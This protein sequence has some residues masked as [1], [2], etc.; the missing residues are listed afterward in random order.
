MAEHREFLSRRL[1]S[2]LGVIPIGIFLVQH[3][4]VNHFA[5]YGEES[6]NKAAGFMANLPFVLV[7]ETFVIYLP[8]LFHAILGV[9]IVFEARNNTKRY[10]FFRNWMFFLQRVT[11]IITLVFIAWHVWETRVQVALGNAEV[12]YSLMEGILSSPIMFWFYIIGVVSAV[13]HFA[14]GLW[15]FA[16][17][18]GL[19]Q[20]PKSQKIATYVTVIIFFVVSYIGV[21]TLIQFAYGA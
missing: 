8:I 13:F 1:H 5:V 21:R 17:T 6:F 3:L 16:V 15:S 7:L 4:V 2:L 19:T 9:Y 10:G 14:N 20:S 11:G 18:W 12:N